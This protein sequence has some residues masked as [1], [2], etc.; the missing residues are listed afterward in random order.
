MDYVD[1]IGWAAAAAT[2]TTFMMKTMLP[3]RA[4]SVIANV[5]FISYGGLAGSLPV[6]TLHLTLLPLNSFRLLEIF[7]TT[8]KLRS[9]NPSAGLPAGIAAYLNTRRIPRDT[10][11]FR[12]GD[13][14]DQIYFLKS[15]RVL[16]EE[17]GKEMDAGELFGEIAFF[18]RNRVR[19][20]TARCT[21]DCELATISEADFTRLFYQN[22]D[23]GFFM[24]RL[25]AGRLEEGAGQLAADR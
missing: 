18:G 12:R 20:L 24:L 19:S 5:L 7:R 17:I 2:F 3:L 25:L 6:L 11:I 4:A 15:G 22:P 8:R 23:F 13:P 21:E 16:L 9:A 1:W 10:V 14:A